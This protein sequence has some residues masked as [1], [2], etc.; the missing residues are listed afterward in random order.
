M[1]KGSFDWVKSGGNV[2][3]FRLVDRKGVSDAV[4]AQL[5]PRISTMLMDKR[6]R[7]LLDEWLRELRERIEVKVNQKLWEAL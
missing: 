7:E 2:V 6:K 4:V 3:V 5:T 1:D